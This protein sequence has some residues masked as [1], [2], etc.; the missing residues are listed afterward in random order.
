MDRAIGHQLTYTERR[1]G[2]VDREKVKREI[3]Y[4]EE[5]AG[6]TGWW[7]NGTRLYST[8]PREREEGEEGEGKA[9]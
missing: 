6:T 8:R 5:R 2:E 3:R 4:L 1:R 9:G 7:G